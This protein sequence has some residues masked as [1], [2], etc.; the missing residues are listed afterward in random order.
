M[1]TPR[2]FGHQIRGAY[3][4]ACTAMILL[5]HD[6]NLVLYDVNNRQLQGL[7]TYKKYYRACCSVTW[8]NLR[9]NVIS[10]RRYPPGSPQEPFPLNTTLEVSVLPIW[11]RFLEKTS[12]IWWRHFTARV[13]GPFWRNHQQDGKGYC[14]ISWQP[15]R[16]QIFFCLGSP[17]WSSLSSSCSYNHLLSVCQHQATFWTMSK[18]GDRLWTGVL[19]QYSQVTETTEIK[20]RRGGGGQIIP[21]PLLLYFASPNPVSLFP[22]VNKP[23]TNK[24][25][26]Q[27]PLTTA[28]S[29]TFFV[30]VN[31]N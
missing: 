12:W 25:N 10:C 23:S 8:F 30:A 22:H 3:I 15:P 17:G 9:V 13:P 28:W 19:V 27:I 4:R 1:S 2:A 16:R 14:L 11:E 31:S 7:H 5:L 20:G 21:C 6:I 24:R 18:P 29:T 26:P